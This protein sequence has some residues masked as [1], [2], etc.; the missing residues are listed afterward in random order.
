[1]LDVR[2]KD[3]AGLAVDL[4]L[5]HNAVGDELE[6]VD[7]V[8]QLILVVGERGMVK[9]H[10]RHRDVLGGLQANEP[11]LALH[12]AIDHHGVR[13]ETKTAGLGLNRRFDTL[14]EVRRGNAGAGLEL[15]DDV[16]VVPVDLLVKEAVRVDVRDKLCSDFA[17]GAALVLLGIGH[18]LAS[19][20]VLR[21]DLGD[22]TRLVVLQLDLRVDAQQNRTD[23]RIARDRLDVLGRR[24]CAAA[25]ERRHNSRTHTRRHR[26]ALHSALLHVCLLSEWLCFS[27]IGCVGRVLKTGS[28]AKSFFFA[29]SR[30]PCVPVRALRQALLTCNPRVAVRKSPHI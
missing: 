15:E 5:V 11:V 29:R 25:R 13:S 17:Y 19:V 7:A 12:V 6:L 18:H 4:V 24:L 9:A 28:Q 27:V 20:V 2:L 14:E 30:L 8:V 22:E 10:L 23:R 16:L 21:L 1:M 26:Q 3:L